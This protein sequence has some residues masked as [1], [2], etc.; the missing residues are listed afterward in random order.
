MTRV[1]VVPGVAV[2]LTV[3]GV[4]MLADGR[5]V[6]RMMI[7]VV[8]R[9]GV[10]R[11]HGCFIYNLIATTSSGGDRPSAFNNIVDVILYFLDVMLPGEPNMPP[12][13]LPLL[14]RSRFRSQRVDAPRTRAD[15]EQV[16]KNEAEQH[17]VLAT[18]MYRPKAAW[19]MRLKENHRHLARQQKSYRSSQETKDDQRAAERLQHSSEPELGE[20]RRCAVPRPPLR[21]QEPKEF[22]DAV[23]HQ[24]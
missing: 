16:Q 21:D 7:V 9:L 19:E 14:R 12:G 20:D 3:T 11:F 23:L 2:S 8:A 4:L 10:R 18:I 24:E 6:A 22:L 17:H 15:G 1:L 5:L 13:G